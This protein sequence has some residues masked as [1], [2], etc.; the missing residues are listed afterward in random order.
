MTAEP[1]AKSYSPPPFSPI[2][3]RVLGAAERHSNPDEETG[4]IY[5]RPGMRG[6][7][8][9]STQR[10][11]QKWPWKSGSDGFP[12][13][14]LMFSWQR[15]DDFQQPRGNQGERH[16]HIFSTSTPYGGLA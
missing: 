10:A 1:I 7:I 8:L 6:P 9:M 15:G 14:F 4:E 13:L 16:F 2:S 11:R 12:K 3:G 5:G